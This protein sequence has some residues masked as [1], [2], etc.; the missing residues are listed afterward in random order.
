MKRLVILR[1]N[2]GK[3]GKGELANQLWN[4]M[5]IYAY[6]LE[7]H[8]PLDNY[9]FFEYSCYFNIT[10]SHRLVR[11]LFFAP[12][13]ALEWLLGHT[14]ATI[15]WRLLYKAFVTAVGALH[16][17]TTL[18]SHNSPDVAGIFYLPPTEP[19]NPKIV[20]LQQ[21]H[22]VQTIYFDGWLFRNPEGMKKYRSEIIRYF[23]PKGKIEDA[24]RAWVTPLKQR[25]EH[26]VGVHVRQ[27]DYRT[28]KNGKYFVGQE[29]IRN[30]LD[31]YLQ[32]YNRDSTQTCFVI[33]SNEP[34]NERIFAGLQTVVSKQ[35]FIEDLFI[36]ASTDTVIGS[37]SSFGN[38]AAYIAD[39]PHIVVSNDVLD[40]EYYRGKTRYFQNKY[41]TL[42][43]F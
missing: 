37:D 19:A 13:P 14:R 6:A 35:S 17:K 8:W 26:V 41:C 38:F 23:R 42:V 36:L 24:V 31:E 39:V 30:I 4:F 15:Y 20:A 34:I 3:G 10:V 28:F 21:D 16:S 12:F 29:R 7:C 27:G 33:T 9:S 25:Y 5:S 32:E 43:H 1:H 22:T 11:I 40:W 2:S 18:C